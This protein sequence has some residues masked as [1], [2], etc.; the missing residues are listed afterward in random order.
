MREKQSAVEQELI[1]NLT[2]L[3]KLYPE[4]GALHVVVGDY[5]VEDR[6]IK[7]NKSVLK[8]YCKN[9]EEIQLCTKICDGLLLFKE[10]QRCSI[11]K[12]SVEKMF[13][14]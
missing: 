13:G 5:N 11:L 2:K 10:R 6:H 4:G 3:Y 8:K 7:W 12:K 1:N 14:G 9:D